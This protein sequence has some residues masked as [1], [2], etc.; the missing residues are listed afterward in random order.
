MTVHPEFPQYRADMKKCKMLYNT[1]AKIYI[2]I[3]IFLVF[4][5]IPSFFFSATYSGIVPFLVLS[6]ALIPATVFCGMKSIYRKSTKY[7]YYALISS[8]LGLLCVPFSGVVGICGLFLFILSV[9]SAVLVPIANKKYNFLEQ[10]EGFPYF[11]DLHTEEMKKG[12][13]ALKKDPYQRDERFYAREEVRGVMDDFVTSDQTL[14][15]K[16]DTKNDYMDSV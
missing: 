12:E 10:Q 6:L 9:V 2:L 1:L 3:I 7:V 13:E 11:S 15:A 16:T 4:A 8:V 5:F 14:D